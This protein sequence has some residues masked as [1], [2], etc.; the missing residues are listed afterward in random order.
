MTE[1]A[2]YTWSR[3]DVV[4][5]LGFARFD[6]GDRRILVDGAEVV[7][8]G[9]QRWALR[10]HVELDPGWRTRAA[11]LVVTDSVQGGERRRELRADGA[12]AWSVDAVPAP[13]LDG[14]LDLDVGA[15]P[16]SN[17]FAIRRTAA[18]VGGQASLAAA[19]VDVP[20]LEVQR[21]AQTYRHLDE[22]RWEYADDT[23]GSFTLT[24]DPHG[25]V[26]DYPG[27]ARLV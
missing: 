12:G 27:L 3:L 17:T 1:M 20:S 26:T 7:A 6:E 19:F 15:V 25:I 9:D 11:D 22:H 8:D 4:Q 16:F 18:P 14:C 21:L 2:S 5:G 23:Y 13:A 24:V 10:F